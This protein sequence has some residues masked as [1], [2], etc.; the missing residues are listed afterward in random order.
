MIGHL[1]GKVISKKPGRVLIDV[2]GVGYDVVVPS[3]YLSKPITVSG[4]VS[5]F[6]YTHVREDQL[7]LYGFFTEGEKDLFQVLLSISGIGPKVALTLLS[8]IS[9]KELG[10][11]VLTNNVNRLTSIQGIG[12]KTAERLVLEMKEKIKKISAVIYATDF[13][14]KSDVVMDLSSA[15][16][17]LGY[18]QIEIDRALGQLNLNHTE[19]FEDLLKQTLKI[20][21]A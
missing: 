10:Q 13:P 14:E 11:V 6:V 4:E 20:L 8:E 19:K 12:K 7:Q 2:Q 9:P 1:R 16:S 21:R 5:F 18:K 15:L 17:N 3:S